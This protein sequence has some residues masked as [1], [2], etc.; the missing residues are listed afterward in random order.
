MAGKKCTH[1]PQQYN[2][3]NKIGKIVSLADMPV[4]KGLHPPGTIT[5]TQKWQ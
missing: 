4:L 1:E 5:D 2:Y 3:V